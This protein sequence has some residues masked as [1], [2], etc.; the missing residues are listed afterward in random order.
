MAFAGM[1]MILYA[2]LLEG[3]LLSMER[4]VVAMNL[5]E[6]QIHPLGYRTDPDLYKR[7]EDPSK[8]LDELENRNLFA[9]SRLYGFGL[10]ASDSSSSGVRLRGVDL[11]N[12]SDVTQIHRHVMRGSW[13]DE[14]DQNGVVLGRKLARSLNVTLGEEL[15]VVSQATDGSIANDLFRVR[16]ILKAVDEEMDRAGF[17][18][19]DETFRTL[20]V[21]PNGVHE[22]AILRKDRTEDLQEVVR[23]IQQMTPGYSVMQWRGLKPVLARA[24]DLSDASL[25]I[26]LLIAY[27]AVAMVILNAMLM[28]VFERIREFGVMKALGVTPYQVA[29]VIFLEAM[30]QTAVA[31]VLAIALGW[32]VSLF[33][34]THGINLS[35]QESAGTIAGVAL[36]P[37]LYSLV[38]PVV[39]LKPVVFLFGISILAVIY[40]AI[41]AAVIRPVEAIHYR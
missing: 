7:I 23:R 11:R 10:A 3:L 34:E 9:S 12:E 19:L 32:P 17:F 6:I 1:I 16:G 31:G 26:M 20:M 21:L 35:P 4:N 2:A 37:T 28:T 24:L 27:T 41:K 5:G 38:T 14:S 15:V 8:L 29:A 22:I 18:M 36:D 13:L 30:I 33:F 39:I 25:V 40:P